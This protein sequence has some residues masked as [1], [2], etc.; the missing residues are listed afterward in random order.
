M[1]WVAQITDSHIVPHGQ[2]LAN[3]PKIDTAENLELVVRQINSLCP[4]PDLVIHTGDITDKGDTESYNRAKVILDKLTVPYYLTCGNHDIYRNMREVFANHTYLANDEF[5]CYTIEFDKHKLVVI[6]STNPG[7]TS[8]IL[9]DIRL[10]WLRNEL[11]TNKAVSI[12]IHHYPTVVQHVFFNKFNVLN[13]EEL[14]KII[15]MPNIKGIYCG[16]YH[17][18]GASIF[19]GKMC[20]LAPSTSPV[21][22]LD[23]VVNDTKGT[24]LLLTP[25]SFS[26]HLLQDGIEN[27]SRVV[28]CGTLIDRNINSAY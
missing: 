5:A 16:H 28:S 20:W 17:I 2:H 10:S 23:D 27:I 7:K 6:D 22:H 25:P 11:K 13:A 12:F 14:A 4:L 21:F 9:C 24:K 18:T 3:N 15:N 8:G 26:I 19:A 1:L